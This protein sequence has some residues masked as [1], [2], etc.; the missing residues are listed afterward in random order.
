MPSRDLL[1]DLTD[2]QREAVT[3]T[4]GPLLILAAAGSGKT[5][6]IMRRVAHL[7]QLGVRAGNI[8][9][10]T[11]TNKA[12]GEMRQRV[13]DLAPGNRVW[14]STF[15]SFG[16]RLLRQ[17]ADSFSLDRN[18]TIYD[19]SDRSRLLKMALEDAGLDNNRFSPDSI[20]AAISKAKNQL[21]S[22]ER[23]AA[24]ANDFYGQTVARVYPIYESAS[25]LQRPRL[26]RPTPLA[27]PRPPQ[28]RRTARE[29]DARFRYVLIDE[30]Q[31]TNH[32]Q[33]AI[34]RGLS[35]DNPN[36]CVVGDPDQSIYKFR[37]SDIRNILDFERDFPSARTLT[38]A[39][40]YRSTKAILLAAG[41]LIAHNKQ[42]KPKDL[43]TDNADGHPVTVLTFENGQ[44]EAEGIAKRIR[45]AVTGGKRAY[46][47]F[48][49]FLRINA[50][51]RGLET[52]FVR[53]RVPFQI[54]KGLAFFDRKENKD[55]LAYLA[56]PGQS[57]RRFILPARCE[58]A[59]ARRR[60][61]VA[62]TFARLR[63][64]A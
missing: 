30:Y 53:Q 34:A 18:F 31:D 12:A 13:E 54:V 49:V 43:Q 8:L 3:H 7:L 4:E 29:L 11:F 28:Q 9:A 57:A 27:R 25:R 5:R 62:G 42:R 44:D 60:Q 19:M 17:Y 32:A 36:L 24:G 59:G 41:A 6:V 63:R 37:G 23:Y 40:N 38:L 16:A 22:P 58:R 21:L 46:R 35:I 51:S 33:Y 10:I 64:T 15:H 2:A 39:M 61:S 56:S 20:G 45:E 26:R 1:A 47:D 55:V 52:A 48:A 14:I 50:L